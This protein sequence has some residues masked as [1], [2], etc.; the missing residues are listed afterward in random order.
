[1]SNYFASKI[2]EINNVLSKLFTLEES[3]RIFGDTDGS[4]IYDKHFHSNSNLVIAKLIEDFSKAEKGRFAHL[5]PNLD[6][7]LA[8]ELGKLLAPTGLKIVPV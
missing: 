6:A 8:D 7:W 2:D 4:R 1:M 3:K 5:R